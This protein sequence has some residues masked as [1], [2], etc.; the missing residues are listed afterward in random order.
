MSIVIIGDIILDT[1]YI[2][3]VNRKA[4]EADIPIYNILD[5]NYILG[6]ASNVA[7]NLKN[8]DINIDLVSVIGNDENGN[9]IKGILNNRNIKNYLLIDKT[10]KTTEKNRIFYNDKITVRYDIEDPTDISNELADK[11]L[12]YIKNKS[13]IH[14]II[15]SDY[16]KG[17]VTEYLSQNLIEYCNKNNI[18]T[19]VDP[20]IKNVNK[21]KNCFLFKPN[22]HEANIITKKTE[23]NDILNELNIVLSCNNILLTNGEKGMYLNSEENHIYHDKKI[24][25]S[26]VTGAGDIVLTIITY[27]FYKE[28][29]LM[30]ATK[31]ANYIAGKSV[32]KIGNYIVS[33]KDIDDYYL[34]TNKII[35]ENESE[36]IKALSKN[37]NIVFT[38]GCFDIIHSAHV[39]LLQFAKKKGN[40]LVVGLNS[41]Q[42]I[43]N[44]K[45]ERRPINDLDER[46]ELLLNLNIIDY[47][48][49]FDNNTPYNILKNL[50]PQTIIKGGDY[51]REQ[52]I[53]SE[54]S[55]QIILF[56]FIKNK[57]TSLIVDKIIS[58]S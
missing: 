42:S 44:I 25:V 15:I 23:I 43:K 14:S 22:F 34:I 41:D 6:G 10:R 51:T 54:F 58:F 57:S 4:P 18:Y 36:K 27:I 12:E 9:K 7:H 39:K 53:G 21:Y 37:K 19:F 52:I 24:T 26:D 29:D 31:I 11:I 49:V 13:D 47:I 1:N 38:N 20:K 48:I 46:C 28:N 55:E 5:V 2:S 17:V 56:D 40:M 16:D 3:I 45:G 32:T 35:H 8:L 30:L 33:K 50:K